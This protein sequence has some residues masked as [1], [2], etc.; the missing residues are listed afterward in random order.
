MAHLRFFI[1]YCQNQRC[2]GNR[3]YQQ[4]AAQSVITALYVGQLKHQGS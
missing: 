1:G 4:L 3:W 2:G